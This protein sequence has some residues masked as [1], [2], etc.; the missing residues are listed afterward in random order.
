MKS[1]QTKYRISRLHK[2]VSEIKHH[3]FRQATD[4]IRLIL[5]TFPKSVKIIEKRSK[6]ETSHFHVH[7]ADG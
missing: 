3:V 4:A 6:H 2:H 7:T 1:L 5:L